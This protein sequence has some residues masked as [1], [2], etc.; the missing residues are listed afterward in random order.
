MELERELSTKCSIYES[1]NA[2][3]MIIFLADIL[4]NNFNIQSQKNRQTGVIHREFRGLS[5]F[6]KI[7][8]HI[9][10]GVSLLQQFRVLIFHFKMHR[11]CFQYFV[12]SSYDEFL[13]CYMAIEIFLQCLP[14]ALGTPMQWLEFSTPILFRCKNNNCEPPSPVMQC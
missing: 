5:P 14:K 10:G 8:V 12:L 4:E 7:S 6:V 1:P 11:P 2:K 13:P 3:A 9:G